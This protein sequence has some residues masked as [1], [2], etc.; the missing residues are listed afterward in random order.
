MRTPL[1]PRT[2]RMLSRLA[3]R[4]LG[5][6]ALV[7]FVGGVVFLPLLHQCEP[8]TSVNPSSS[9]W[10]QLQASWDEST[11][12]ALQAL[13]A[14]IREG[15][16]HEAT[17]LSVVIPA[18]SSS[19]EQGQHTHGAGAR[20]HSHSPTH[21]PETEH[22]KDSLWHFGVSITSTCVLPDWLGVPLQTLEHIIA[23]D[24]WTGTNAENTPQQPRAPPV[25]T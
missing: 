21:V 12:D 24:V 5:V 8:H 18:V 17:E 22:G 25:T 20:S 1:H 3:H 13:S 15:E 23:R 19:Q 11:A 2:F 9:A 7:W 4:S 14:S 16:Q 6:W 10:V